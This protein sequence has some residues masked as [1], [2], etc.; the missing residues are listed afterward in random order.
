[1]DQAL[2]STGPNHDSMYHAFSGRYFETYL[3]L[4]RYFGSWYV[5][6]NGWKEHDEKQKDY[7]SFLKKNH[8]HKNHQNTK[9]CQVPFPSA[10]CS[11]PT[12]GVSCRSICNA[13][14]APCP[15][16]YK[17]HRG[18]PYCIGSQDL[19]FPH[20]RPTFIYIYHMLLRSVSFK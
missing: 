11:P 12:L 6:K 15:S 8:S 13:I 16:I 9:L 19:F 3:W 20:W 10:A 4:E 18:P 2:Q 1:M 7:R 14:G 17:D 5:L